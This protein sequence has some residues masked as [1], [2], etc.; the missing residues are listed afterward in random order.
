MADK[1]RVE[2][3]SV[4]LGIRSAIREAFTGAGYELIEWTDTSRPLRT[5]IDERQQ[6][7]AIGRLMLPDRVDAV[8][9]KTSLSRSVEGLAATQGLKQG[10]NDVFAYVLPEALP[11]LRAK[12]DKLGSLVIVGG[13]QAR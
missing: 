8:V 2:L 5:D 4:D 11:A 1:L 13:D 7:G 3:Y 6:P 12:L 10:R 9:T